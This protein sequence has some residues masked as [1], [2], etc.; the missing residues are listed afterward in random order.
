MTDWT[1]KITRNGVEFRVQNCGHDVL[2]VRWT[3]RPPGLVWANMDEGSRLGVA[4]VEP[5][6]HILQA[7]AKFM[8][9]RAKKTLTRAPA[10]RKASS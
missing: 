8:S 2:R 6:Q 5:P 3:K 10:S 7:L 1:Y 4:H 9:A